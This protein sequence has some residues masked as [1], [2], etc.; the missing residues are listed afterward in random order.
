MLL[1]L[2][3]YANIPKQT[4][5]PTLASVNPVNSAVQ[6]TQPSQPD[7]PEAR[8]Y[9]SKS[10][11]WPYGLLPAGNMGKRVRL[12]CVYNYPHAEFNNLP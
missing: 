5:N 2:S 11:V 8:M 7:N 9:G 6:K 4:W 1:Y 10:K 12:P 3:Q